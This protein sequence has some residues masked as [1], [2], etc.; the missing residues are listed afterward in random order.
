[1][2]I[3]NFTST[4]NLSYLHPSLDYSIREAEVP[5]SFGTEQVIR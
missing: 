4:G 1:M 2:D 5:N 3:V